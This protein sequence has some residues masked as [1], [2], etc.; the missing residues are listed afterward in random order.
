MPIASDSHA[1]PPEEQAGGIIPRRPPRFRRTRQVVRILCWIYAIAMI[2]L[3]LV[4]RFAGD[5][6]W[7]AT[8]TLFGPNWIFAIPL[9]ALVP[10]A[11]IFRRRS[12]WTLGLAAFVIAVPV[13]D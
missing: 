1:R 3:W 12:L 11:A 13:M 9:I 4:L 5:Q 10:A 7:L 8:L 2:A 6:W